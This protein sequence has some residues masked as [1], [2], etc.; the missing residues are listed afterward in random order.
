M[1]NDYILYWE[2]NFTAGRDILPQTTFYN[3]ASFYLESDKTWN[4]TKL[5][6]YNRASDHW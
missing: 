3:F 1:I 6:K 5:H 4:G 2:R